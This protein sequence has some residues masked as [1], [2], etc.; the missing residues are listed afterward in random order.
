MLMG[1][2]GVRVDILPALCHRRDRGWWRKGEGWVRE[3][4]EGTAGEVEFAGGR[5]GC[6]PLGGRIRARGHD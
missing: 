5:C 3:S 6:E 1:R 2:V 4:T